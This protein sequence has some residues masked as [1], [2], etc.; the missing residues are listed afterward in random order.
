MRII[1]RV[2]FRGNKK[3][4]GA[5]LGALLF[6]FALVDS[7][8]AVPF[9]QVG[10]TRG[11]SL[12]IQPSTL[13]LPTST[14][15]TF[16][17][18]GGRGTRTYSIVSGGGT[19]NS[20][21]GLFTSA[22]SGGT[23]IVRITDAG[24]A[25]SQATVTV[26]GIVGITVSQ[27]Y[28]SGGIGGS[29]QI[30]AQAINSPS[31]SAD[32]TEEGTWT[33]SNASVATVNK[34]L[35]S[36]VGGGT[37]TVQISYG[38]Y[39]AN[40]SVNVAS[41]T[42][43]GITVTPGTRSMGV[44]ATQDFVATATY[45]DSS[46]Q[47]VTDTVTWFTTNSSVATISN[48]APQ[49][50]R[51]QGV[52]A[53]SVT[54]T[55][56]L[57]ATT[58]TATLTINA[59]TLTSITVTPASAI[60]MTSATQQMTATGNF[61]DSTSS[62]ITN[63]VTWTS[64]NTSAATISNVAGSKGLATTPSFTGFR[65]TTITATLG[66]ISGNTTLNVNGATVTAVTVNPTVTIT[67]GSTYPMSAVATLSDGG[68]LDVTESATWTSTATN[69]VTVS[70]SVGYQG[71]VTG[72][73]AGTS[74]VRAAF[75]GQTGQRTVT[76]GASQSVSEEGTG[77]LGE[78]YNWTGGGVPSP[79]VPGNKVGQ[80]NDA[81]IAFGWTTGNNPMG[82][83]E[84]FAVRWTGYYEAV[85]GTNRFCTYSDDG[86]RVW[87][88]GVQIINNWTAHAATW[89]CTASNVSLTAGQKYP[90]IVEFFED[91]GDATMYF[92]RAN[93]TTNAQ[94]ISAAIPMVDLFPP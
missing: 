90:L 73:S 14:S 66:A 56:T 19:I 13:T 88:N 28:V 32:I 60:I 81:N 2:C 94:Q 44:N 71:R 18:N 82:V 29:I 1:E 15:H 50:G 33:T 6:T 64:S 41:K 38:G 69:R 26:V 30:T 5:G 89:N 7:S 3:W 57:G 54:V 42:L 12:Y 62:N 79:F 21:T 80:R 85:S 67:V 35:I 34:G 22:A 77:L 17:A 68:T 86:V 49:W 83:A 84:K 39:T 65:S 48:M 45:S 20:S 24:G 63:Q 47:N 46:T 27:G 70:N 74:S 40:V 51:A 93:N 92:T 9:F 59:A 37:A 52:A 10:A 23:T 91:G 53:G 8:Q 55:A 76:V 75:G 11:G 87:L 25:T 78:Y 16:F 72:I 43:T 31:G 58:G 4:I 61:S 36:F